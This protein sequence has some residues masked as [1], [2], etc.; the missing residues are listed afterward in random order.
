M[1]K[2][3]IF[4]ILL[5]ILLGSGNT[6]AFCSGDLNVTY[7]NLDP[8]NI[9][10]EGEDIHT[11]L[12]FSLSGDDLVTENDLSLALVMDK[13]GSM[14]GGKLGNAK[15]ALY[16][17]VDLLRDTGNVNNKASLVTFN[18]S[19]Y[20]N[21]SLTNNYNSLDS[22]IGAISAGGS[23]SVGGGLYTGAYTLQNAPANSKKFIILAS[24]GQ[25]NSGVSVYSGMNNVSSDTTVYTI[26]INA[27]G[28]MKSTLENIAHNSGTGDG[29][30]Y[31]SN[32]NDLESVLSGI[33][34]NII[35]F[36]AKDSTISLSRANLGN[37]DFSSAS[38]APIDLNANPLV[39]NLGDLDSSEGDVTID[40]NLSVGAASL[41]NP[42]PINLKDIV[43]KYTS[44]EGENCVI[45]DSIPII[46]VLTFIEPT[47]VDFNSTPAD[48]GS[49]YEEDDLTLEWKTENAD[50][51]EASGNDILWQGGKASAELSYENETINPAY[52]SSINPHKYSMQCFR[53]YGFV[54][55][56]STKS[57][58]EININ[59]CPPT[60]NYSCNVNASESE[61]CGAYPCGVT[62]PLSNS[63]LL[64]AKTT[65]YPSCAKSSSTVS[66]S[67][68]DCRN[69]SITGEPSDICDQSYICPECKDVDKWIEVAP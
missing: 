67:V 1:K 47:I 68:D 30:Y 16:N 69:P 43:F 18:S 50:Y 53:D 33:V 19:A 26:G 48:G 22:A 27:S 64:C 52:D 40:V 61:I 60:V 31:Y 8:D 42:S 59:P 10:A 58:I 36:K 5:F 32:T 28:S 44:L 51:C 39:W 41:N 3:Y 6:F 34:E 62:T 2:A 66:V 37:F 14:N 21:M 24:D 12:S 46:D 17:V 20:V 38:P 23:T 45:N 65:S 29:E 7:Q 9:Y 35:E 63:Q 4:F 54:L 49:M 57:T 25:H 11:R 55:A 56:K 15:S 13:S